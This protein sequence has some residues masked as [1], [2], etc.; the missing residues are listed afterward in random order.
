MDFGLGSLFD[1]LNRKIGA[2]RRRKMTAEELIR[3][4]FQIRNTYQAMVLRGG[5]LVYEFEPTSNLMTLEGLNDLLSKYWKGS[6]YTAAFYVA[7]I[8]RAAAA[9]LG[10]S[11]FSTTNTSALVT[12]THT[13][14]GLL[15][16]D[17]IWFAGASAVAGLTIAGKYSVTSVTNANSYVITAGGNAN[18]TTTGGGS[19]VTVEYVGGNDT[20]AKINAT[21]NWPT[22]NGWQ[23]CTAYNESV[24]QTLTL[25]SISAQ[26]VD[27]SASK[28]AFSI[29]G[30]K[31]IDGA[32]IVTN[33][34]KTSTSGLIA[35]EA[36]FATSRDVLSGDT[37]QV[38]CN[39]SAATG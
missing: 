14:H 28:A 16:G 2:R 20:A 15:V 9:T 5:K 30:T 6:S 17:S 18:A 29:N 24:R 37:L 13:S 19:S 4:G 36:M 26:A 35:G 11:P 27:N 7:P 10:S 31:T 34:G 1:L 25:G 33:S 38:Q 39:L 32:C 22:T 3:G 21:I 8:E 23:L 12:V